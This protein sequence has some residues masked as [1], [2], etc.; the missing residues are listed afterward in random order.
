[1]D[2]KEKV[3]ANYI[4]NSDDVLGSGTWGSVYK[5][6]HKFQK[7]KLYAVKKMNKFKI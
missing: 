4:Y 6:R 1:M 7:A 3:A 2:G 5:A